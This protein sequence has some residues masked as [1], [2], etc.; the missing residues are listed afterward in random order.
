MYYFFKE[1]DNFAG[2][3]IT[4]GV[5]K[6]KVILYD[7]CFEIPIVLK[8]RPMILPTTPIVTFEPAVDLVFR[9]E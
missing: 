5:I 7:Q 2:F 1:A 4:L 8:C 6:E 3:T 9:A